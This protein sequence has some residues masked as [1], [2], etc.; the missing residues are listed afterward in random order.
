[1]FFLPALRRQSDGTLGA[2]DWNSVI[3]QGFGFGSQLIASL[4]KRPTQQFAYSQG[5]GGIFAL[6][7]PVS[8]YDSGGGYQPSQLTA[9]QYA[10]LQQSTR[11][12]VAEDAFSSITSFISRNPVLVAGGALGVY[13]L[14]RE[15]PRSRR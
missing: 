15:P 11:G 3:N 2:I 14:F 4:G 8:G 5:S 9:A 10:Q 1:M 13:L 12:G 6:G 7:T